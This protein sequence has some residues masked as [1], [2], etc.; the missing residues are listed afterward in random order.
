[1]YYA[2]KLIIHSSSA[3]EQAYRIMKVLS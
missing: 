1:L 3:V 2:A